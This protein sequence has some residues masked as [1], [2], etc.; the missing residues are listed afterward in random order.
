MYYILVIGFVFAACATTVDIEKRVTDVGSGSINNSGEATGGT[1]VI[2]VPIDSGP[3]EV[4]VIEKP[5][6]VPAAPPNAPPAASGRTA[7]QQSNAAGI[8]Q[9]SDYSKAAMVYDYDPDWVYEIYTQPLRASDIRLEPGERALEAPFVS[10][11][12]RWILGAGV[13]LEGGME[14]QHIYIKPTAISLEASLIIN[15]TR[16]VYH[17]ILKSFRDVH[18]PMIRW[19]YFSS[20]MPNT[21]ITAI[22]ERGAALAGTENSAGAGTLDPR[23]LSFNY[24]ITYSFFSKPRWLPNLVYDDGKKTYIAFPP[25]VLQ[26]QL[27]AVF[28]N[29]NNVVNYRVLENIII[30]DKLIEKITVKKENKE[31]VIEKKKG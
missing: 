12:E 14:I 17:L 21:Y 7:V 15:T 20:A 9:P 25:E 28:E 26:S 13:S 23:F 19:R 27:P 6:Y 8:M 4:I 5:M 3:P 24:K 31:I 18:M 16:R 30:I 10:D 2:T 29:R 22:P 1:M 11:S